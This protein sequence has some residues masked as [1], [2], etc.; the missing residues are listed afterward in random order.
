MGRHHVPT[1]SG[2]LHGRLLH[3]LGVFSAVV[4]LAAVVALWQ[5][6]GEDDRDPVGTLDGPE[7]AW[8]SP[9]EDGTSATAS[10]DAASAT[11][12]S[13]SA[14]SA[15]PTTEAPSE[16]AASTAEAEETSA[17]EEEPTREEEHAPAGASCSATLALAEEWRGG[18]TVTVAVVNTGDGEIDSWAIDLDL[19]DAEVTS[20]WNMEELGRDWYG[21]SGW[22]G[23]LDPG[24]DAVVGFQ[25][26]TDWDF[27]MPDSVPCAAED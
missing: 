4:A 17:R 7:T 25:A 6:G 1:R 24:E 8:L 12:A 23:R 5:F 18:A 14:S 3:V 9:G 27:E 2:R 21:D 15:S 10:A 22:N 16:A 20:T 26:E 13:P 19:D 11:S